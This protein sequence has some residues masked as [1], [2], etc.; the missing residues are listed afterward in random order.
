MFSFLYV[1]C[2]FRARGKP[3]ALWLFVRFFF[4]YTIFIHNFSLWFRFVFALKTFCACFFSFLTVCERIE[5]LRVHIA[6]KKEKFK[7]SL[8]SEFKRSD[9]HPFID[10]LSVGAI[11]FYFWGEFSFLFV[12]DCLRS[13]LPKVCQRSTHVRKSFGGNVNCM[14]WQGFMW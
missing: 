1:H 4:S 6:E 12:I 7:V 14:F 2:K 3:C 11:L 5:W 10:I 13:L 9:N 8:E